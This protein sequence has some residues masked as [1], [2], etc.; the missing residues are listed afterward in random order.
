VLRPR[1]PSFL[2][3]G[4][5][6]QQPIGA[7]WARIRARLRAAAGERQPC[8]RAATQ[9]DLREDSNCASELVCRGMGSLLVAKVLDLSVSNYPI[10]RL[11]ILSL[12]QHRG[13]RDDGVGS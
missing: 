9:G 6:L 8:R 12:Y 13:V 4:A 5:A 1:Q 3:R 2:T 11:G 7:N 10:G